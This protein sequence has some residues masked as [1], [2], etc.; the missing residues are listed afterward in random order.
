MIDQRSEFANKGWGHLNLLPFYLGRVLFSV[1][2]GLLG[3]PSTFGG[4]PKGGGQKYI[5]YCATRDPW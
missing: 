4:D 1:G 3:S 5:F 2:P